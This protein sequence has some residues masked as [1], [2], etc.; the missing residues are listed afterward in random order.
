MKYLTATRVKL[1][2]LN[3]MLHIKH[4][5]PSSFATQLFPELTEKW[6][7][8]SAK[9]YYCFVL[10]NPHG[11]DPIPCSF[12]PIQFSNFGIRQAACNLLRN[13]IWLSDYFF[14]YYFL[15]FYRRVFN[16]ECSTIVYKCNVPAVTIRV[17]SNDSLSL[18][19]D[20]SLKKIQHKIRSTTAVI[21]CCCSWSASAD[22]MLAIN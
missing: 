8:F 7:T 20:F 4:G 16:R 19:Y 21:V 11:T 10:K 15:N 17:D 2:S 3:K 9:H 22:Y 13:T 14:I 1:D 5:L 12:L 18:W 6:N